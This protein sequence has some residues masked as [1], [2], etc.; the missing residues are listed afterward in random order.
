MFP[1]GIAKKASSGYLYPIE[2]FVFK[3]VIP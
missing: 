2:A 3:G 1:E